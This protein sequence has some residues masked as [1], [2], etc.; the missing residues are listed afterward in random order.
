VLVLTRC[1]WRPQ[2]LIGGAGLRVLTRFRW[3]PQHL[4]G[5]I[6]LWVAVVGVIIGICRMPL[7]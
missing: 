1:R 6:G 2:H 7:S 4:F 3:R 5:S